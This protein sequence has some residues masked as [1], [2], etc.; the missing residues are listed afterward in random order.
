MV[1]AASFDF[2]KRKHIQQ[3]IAYKIGKLK[4]YMFTNNIIGNLKKTAMINGI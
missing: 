1:R 2:K 3:I 4:E